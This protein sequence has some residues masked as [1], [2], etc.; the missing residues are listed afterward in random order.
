MINVILLVTSKVNKHRIK[1]LI[2]KNP[3][4]KCMA[5]NCG[6]WFKCKSELTSHLQTHEDVYEVLDTC[7]GNSLL[8][9]VQKEDGTGKIRILHNILLLP[10]RTKITEEME[11]LSSDPSSSQ[12]ADSAVESFPKEEKESQSEPQ[13]DEQS[14]STR[15]WRRSQGPQLATADSVSTSILGIGFI[16]H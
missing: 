16:L 1:V 14:V 11:L 5:S 2:K 15:P 6:C 4:H 10:L 9:K 12:V 8:F 3:S 7:R 13:S